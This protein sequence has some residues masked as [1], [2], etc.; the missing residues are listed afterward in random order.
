MAEIRPCVDRVIP[1]DLFVEA[2]GR[3]VEEDMANVPIVPVRPGVGVAPP[4]PFELAGVTGKKW[5]NGRTLRVTFLDGDHAVQKKVE[6]FA[7]LWKPH[8]NILFEF[9]NDPDSE[10][11][12]SFEQEGSWSFLGTDALTIDRAEPTMNF[13]W[14]TTGTEDEEYERVVVHE[15]GHALACIHEHQNP[16]TNI[17]WDKEAVY[18]YYAGPPNNWTRDQVDNN[19]FRRYSRTITQF[20]AFDG[21]SIMLYPIPNQFTIGDFEVGFNRRLSETDEDFI[22]RLYPGREKSEVDLGIDTAPVEA[23]IGANGEEDTFRFMVANAGQYTIE[24][25]GS[26]DIVMGLFGPDDAKNLVTADDDSGE[27]R[28]A[29]IAA[30]LWPG[31]YLVRIRHYSLSQKGDYTISVKSKAA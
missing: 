23:S 6:H 1:S 18:N 13:G 9:G 21:K 3:A 26:T 30:S 12:I 28:N 7:N 31:E 14:L 2:A 11:R 17:P 25:A 29:K 20:S 22:A 5:K 4:T 8:A 16:A 24:T 27:D 10:I 15:F 19:L